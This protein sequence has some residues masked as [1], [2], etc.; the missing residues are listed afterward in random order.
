MTETS[1]GDRIPFGPGDTD[2]VPAAWAASMLTWL[3]T[4]HPQVFAA[5]LTHAVGIDPAPA[6]R[7]GQ[8][9]TAP[10]LAVPG[11][12]GPAVTMPNGSH[13]RTG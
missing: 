3:K 13:A 8:G 1:A 6:R 5:A 4:A 2:T 7:R 9:H 11:E 10:A 12:F